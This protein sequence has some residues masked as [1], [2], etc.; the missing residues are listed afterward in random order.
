VTTRSKQLAHHVV[1]STAVT[2][3]YTAPG[4]YRAIL[5]SYAAINLTG[6]A[7]TFALWVTSGDDGQDY[8]IDRQPSL[9]AAAM[10]YQERWVVLE[11]GDVLKVQ[12][13]ATP[14]PVI[15]SGA[16]LLLP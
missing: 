9:A 10:V 6:G 12:G 11:P 8:F 7:L 1:S 4:G 13:T 15:V 3:L 16:E 2:T 5:K 14:F